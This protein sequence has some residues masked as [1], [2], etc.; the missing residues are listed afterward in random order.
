MH[1][2][3]D[4]SRWRGYYGSFGRA[5]TSALRRESLPTSQTVEMPIDSGGDQERIISPFI[6]GAK[7]PALPCSVLYSV[8]IVYS[9]R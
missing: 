3:D 8:G 1:V 6:L 5:T 2:A 4:M 7:K 9:S